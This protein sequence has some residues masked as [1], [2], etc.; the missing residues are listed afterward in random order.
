MYGLGD[1]ALNV[2]IVIHY[3]KFPS[4]TNLDLSPFRLTFLRQRWR[5]RK[6]SWIA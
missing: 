4:S 3:K 2:A 5:R 6:C 1:G